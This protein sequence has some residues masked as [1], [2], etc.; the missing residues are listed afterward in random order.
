M[1]VAE[2]WALQGAVWRSSSA[3][4]WCW[5]A[6]HGWGAQPTGAERLGIAASLVPVSSQQL[7]LLLLAEGLQC[8]GSS[9][10]RKAPLSDR[11]G[12]LSHGELLS[13]Q[14]HSELERALTG[15]A[16]CQLHRALPRGK[17]NSRLLLLCPM[18]LVHTMRGVI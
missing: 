9:Q 6:G 13:L 3:G 4:L 11:E 2:D 15:T 16:S 7:I 10:P 8:H 5:A 1:E 12:F 17:F 14:V 18:D